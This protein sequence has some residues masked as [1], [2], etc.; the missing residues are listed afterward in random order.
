[1]PAI[2]VTQIV[3]LVASFSPGMA[4]T[5]PAVAVWIRSQLSLRTITA[6]YDIPGN[7]RGWC[8][9]WTKGGEMT[10]PSERSELVPDAVLSSEIVGLLMAPPASLPEADA[11]RIRDHLIAMGLLAARKFR[12]GNPC[13]SILQFRV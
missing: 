13:H 6:N 12:A 5:W 10:N 11:V 2:E 4:P 1:M 7:L 3:K 9:P 8:D